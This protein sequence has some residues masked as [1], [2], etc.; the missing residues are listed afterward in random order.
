MGVGLAAVCRAIVVILLVNVNENE[1]ANLWPTT[2]LETDLLPR[3][4]G[5]LPT[6]RP[7]TVPVTCPLET[8]PCTEV[9]RVVRRLLLVGMIVLGV[10]DEMRK[11]LRLEC[12]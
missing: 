4:L 12:I 3:T 6:V 7:E 8:C 11:M 1:S 2:H 10:D 9:L 5:T